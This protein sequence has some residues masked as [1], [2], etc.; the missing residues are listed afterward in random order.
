RPLI[1]EEGKDPSEISRKDEIWEA[2]SGLITIAG[3]KL[4][5]YRKMAETVV[6]LVLKRMHRV[7]IGPCIT[8][9]L[10]LSGGD[11]DGIERF[12]AFIDSKRNE[13]ELYGLSREEGE[14]LAR[15]Y[16]TNVD[17]IFTYAHALGTGDVN[18]PV[19][20]RAEILYS[21]HHEMALSPSDF[22]IRRKG[23]LY[24]NIQLVE[25]YK[26]PVA[27]YM[28]KLLSYSQ[29]EKMSNLLELERHIAEAKV[30]DGVR[31]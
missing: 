24:F 20:I 29:D 16:G 30:K 2:E 12:L 5:G 26:I 7:S 11:F 15:F 31:Q 27:N 6:D 1:Y 9:H 21:I 14:R 4:T 19:A 13:A 17:I 8:E 25:Q 23:D 10:P 22:F 3:G 28:A 18:L